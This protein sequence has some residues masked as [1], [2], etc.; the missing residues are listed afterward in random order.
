VSTLLEQV[1][2][3]LQGIIDS[4]VREDWV[5]LSTAINGLSCST[6]EEALTRLRHLQADARNASALS[7]ERTKALRELD[8]ARAELAGVAAQ[9]DAHLSRSVELAAR[10]T[11]LEARLTAPAPAAV[12]AD[13]FRVGDLVAAA[14]TGAG[15]WGRV[16]GFDAGDVECD[17]LEQG[18]HSHEPSELSRKPVEVG[19][20]VRVLGDARAAGKVHT[21]MRDCPSALVAFEAHDGVVELS[22]L[23]AVA[24]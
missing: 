22:K 4:R 13:G 1:E 7:V 16:I 24:P 2:A 21:M 9:R 10:V 17:Y 11:E 8:A 14:P 6:R 5:E 23:V 15:S 3:M 18:I 19:D 12:E 20:T